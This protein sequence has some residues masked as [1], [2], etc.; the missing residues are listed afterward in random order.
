MPCTSA[1]FFRK[2]KVIALGAETYLLY[3]KQKGIPRAVPR[4]PTQQKGRKTMRTIGWVSLAGILASIL[5]FSAT[6]GEEEREIPLKEVPKVVQAAAAKAV[7]G[8][9]LKEAEVKD[10]AE[11][12]VYELDGVAE[13]KKYE[14]LIDAGG[15][16][17]RAA[18]DDEEEDDDDA[19][20]EDDDDDGEDEDDEDEDGDDDE[21]D[22]DEDGHRE[23]HK[24]APAA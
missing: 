24:E 8:I 19:K 5:T 3:K 15:K 17:L 1:R 18:V 12:Q 14:V 10:T 2:C 16:V 13:G 21:G 11:G 23:H 20:D 9:V 7:P 22:H 4:D 6:A